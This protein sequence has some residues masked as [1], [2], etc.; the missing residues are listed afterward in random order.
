MKEYNSIRLKNNE[1]KALKQLEERIQKPLEHKNFFPND[2]SYFTGF[3]SE[4]NTIIHLIIQ[5]ESKLNEF[6]IE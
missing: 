6:P 5:Y 4:N 2:M 3:Y 1:V